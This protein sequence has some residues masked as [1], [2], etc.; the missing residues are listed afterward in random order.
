MR[1]IH[2]SLCNSS[3]LDIV[4]RDIV[5]AERS[6]GIDSNWANSADESA[7]YLKKYIE[8]EPVDIHCVH[9][10]L[11]NSV[12]RK[13]KKIIWFSHGT[14]EYVFQSSIEE[15][16]LKRHGANDY[17]T[18]KMYYMQHSDVIITF[19]PRHQAII[20]S[21]CDKNARV[22]C[23]PMGIDKAFWYPVS[24]KGKYFGNPSLFT[25]ENCH[26]IKWPYD[27][28]IAWPWVTEQFPNAKLHISNLPYD[29]HRWWFP[30]MTR[31][32]TLFKAYANAKLNREELR[33]AFVS[34]DY[35]IG[36]VRYGDFNRM[37]L[38]AKAC[39]A[40]VI[41][42]FGNEYADYWIKEGDQRNIAKQ[43]ISILQGD[44]A[45]RETLQ[46]LDISETVKCLIDMYKSILQWYAWV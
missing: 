6:F 22:E 42:Y 26:A 43:L 7:E 32:G 39:G 23:I 29:Q 16:L 15:G 28:F 41:S 13:D 12:S 34:T 33:D 2:W 19:W 45:P 3:G 44:V 9:S 38:E 11:P 21:L 17:W 18:M 25:A 14:P 37:C 35:Y 40:K 36:L 10:H 5:K 1:V 30:L 46:V 24:S 27:L 20:K 4:A 8:S 31:N